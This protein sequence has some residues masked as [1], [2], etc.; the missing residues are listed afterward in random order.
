LVVVFDPLTQRTGVIRDRLLHSRFSE[1]VKSLPSHTEV[2]QYNPHEAFHI[3]DSR[4][5]EYD[6]SIPASYLPV[7]DDEGFEL[8]STRFNNLSIVSFI[9]EP[10]FS[11]IFN[12]GEIAER[13]AADIVF[14]PLLAYKR[15]V[16]KK[17]RN[18]TSNR[19][20]V[21]ETLSTGLKCESSNLAV[22][23][24]IERGKNDSIVI[25]TQSR[26]SIVV[27]GLSLSD[28]QIR[29]VVEGNTRDK[30]KSKISC[31]SC[32]KL[33]T[34][35]MALRN[36][37]TGGLGTDTKMEVDECDSDISD[38]DG[39]YMQLTCRIPRH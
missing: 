39:I 10:V 25:R 16:H 4:A 26:F 9:L 29:A 34:R 14:A 22:C 21:V 31:E 11:E 24:V 32:Y 7:D 12:H 36:M 33:D 28:L 38:D 2:R 17:S 5:K 1:V 23:G 13:A 19:V 3:L 30:S 6:S 18:L 15:H 20:K 8:Y 27:G 37:F 35:V